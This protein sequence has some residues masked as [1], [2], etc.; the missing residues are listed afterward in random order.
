MP[1]VS[2]DQVNDIVGGK[3]IAAI[4]S[5]MSHSD[6]QTLGQTNPI[7]YTPKPPDLGERVSEDIQ[8]PFIET[9][10]NIGAG[11]SWL[12]SNLKDNT[13]WGALGDRVTRA[14]IVMQ[15]R[16]QDTLAKKFSNFTPNIWDNL[17]GAAPSLAA[18]IGVSAIGAVPATL[19][20]GT[21]VGATGLSIG[22]EEFAKFKAQGHTTNESNALAAAIGIPTT[23][24]MAAGFGVA[25]KLTAP[26]LTR[27]LGDSIAKLVSGPITGATVFGAQGATTGSLELATGA[28]PYE[29]K[30]SLV[31]LMAS[32]ANNAV[33]GGLLGGATAL[34][35]VFKQ[36]AAIIDGFQKLGMSPKEA[37]TNADSLLGQASH[38]V[39]DQLERHVDM[40][41]G[42]QDRIQI[43][44][45][46]DRGQVQPNI[47]DRKGIPQDEMFPAVGDAPQSAQ[48]VAELSAGN[49]YVKLEPVDVTAKINDKATAVDIRSKYMGALDKQI[50]KG[51]YLAED[52]RAMAPTE[53][54][55]AFWRAHYD[56]DFLKR[57]IAD[58][59]A[60][61]IEK[62]RAIYDK[63]EAKEPFKIDQEELE[64]TVME[65]VRLKPILEQ[66][67]NLSEGAKSA[68]SESQLYYKEAGE[69]SKALGTIDDIRE[70]YVSNRLYKPEP[71]RDFVKTIGKG[72][73]KQF[74]AHS[75]ERFYDDPLMAIAGG[76]RFATTNLADLVAIH[77]QEM[78]AVNHSRQLAD[79]LSTIQPMPLGGWYDEGSLP[80]GWS[81][82][83]KVSKSIPIE[84]GSP[85]K[86]R[87]VFA[88]PDGIAKGL[89]ALVDP[90]FFRQNIPGVKDIQKVQGVIKTGILSY[91]FFHDITFATQTLASIGGVD[92][93][94]QMPM[95]FRDKLLQSPG[96]RILEQDA[97]E[98]NLTTAATR[99]VQDIL[100]KPEMKEDAFSEVLKAPVA[101]QLGDISN[102]HTKFLF[103]EYQRWIKVKTYAKEV[104]N[105]IAKNPDATTE[106][107][108]AAKIGFA[109]A[110]NAE[111][112]GLNWEALGV[113]KTIQS[114]LR[115]FLL[116]PDWVV[117]MGLATKYAVQGTF[118]KAGT[119]GIQAR[120]TLFK[121]VAGGL[122]AADGLNYLTTGH[123]LWDNKKGHKFEVEIAPD[124][125][126]PLVR[127]APG[128][129]LKLVSN[130]VESGSLKGVQ[131][132]AEGKA[133]PF[134]SSGITA[135][136]GINYYGADI[137]KGDSPLER[138]VNGIWNV[139]AHDL[140]V[141]IGGTG[142]VDYAQREESK[143][144]LGWG[145]VLSGSG[146]FSKASGATQAAQIR[147]NVIHAYRSGNTDYVDNLIAKGDLSQDEAAKL[148]E[149]SQM[150]DLEIKTQ[151]MRIEK[152]I[153]LYKKTPDVDKPE[154]KQILA[155]KFDRFL[156]S[157]A[158][159]NEKTRIK[160][161]YNTLD[162]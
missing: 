7:Q 23:G 70:N 20:A 19:A 103:G 72:G 110:T 104:T 151:H 148:K 48:E 24:V 47:L 22:A 102:A 92:T 50:A 14:G 144:P 75:L 115:T 95:V 132:Y 156:D 150:S 136:S 124:V 69:V 27:V 73:L 158:S 65:Y 116:A 82:V 57:V 77:N 12:G 145:A 139:V 135:I 160:K 100:T 84:E 15:E 87:M 141:P 28:T 89:K 114:V 34:P 6:S 81:Q 60:V 134:L 99:E 153:I 53:Q 128:E 146:R 46:H 138:S 67:L 25:S 76:K 35:Y 120:G 79:A 161:L 62:Q 129:L 55:A 108:R 38:A 11:L 130:T 122:A 4:P 31:N 159:P 52:M 162:K 142:G 8:K 61:A 126:M 33:L 64:S 157:A 58:P 56:E 32:T 51:T 30:D 106:Q 21:V 83:G 143:S 113:D 152:A 36:H 63:F 43:A 101:K 97:L 18:F 41:P 80:K 93:L 74:S 39:M 137:W 44:P 42:E 112:G 10:H 98:H 90:D 155:E 121:A 94:A 54:D 149:R 131:R 5:T 96:F 147:D 16:A 3:A 78:A 85:F 29:G 37:K 123:H 154:L 86:K 26:W 13:P 71:P 111:F 127:G 105:W 66:A 1:E 68:I 17:V 117:S 125:Y 91:S 2:Y 118:G 40:K 49:K 45:R 59:K 133:S 9:Q 107:L 140:P 109:K 88:A 119:A